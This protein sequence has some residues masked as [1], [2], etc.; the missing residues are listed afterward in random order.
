MPRPVT[1]EARLWKGGRI[2]TGRRWVEALLVEDGRVVAAGPATSVV[3]LA[4]TGTERTDLAG[5]AVVP[6]LIDAHLHPTEIARQREGLD[7]TGVASATE[8]VAA[9]E[10]YGAEARGRPV[11]GRGWDPE[12]WADRR[13]PD[14]R[15][16][17]RAVPD[18]VTIL[19]HASGHAALANA[20]AL[21]AIGIDPSRPIPESPTIGRFPDGR[22]NGLLFEESMTPLGPLVAEAVPVGPEE[23][24]RVA[25]LLASSGIT[26]VGA[27]SMPAGEL[28]ALRS[29]AAAG[30]LPLTVRGYVR[31]GHRRALPRGRRG[32]PSDAV[33]ITGVKLFLDGA[34][35]PRT[36]ALSL[37]YSDDPMTSGVDVG[38]DNDLIAEIAD[39]RAEGLTPALH[40]IGDRAVAR[41]VRLIGSVGRGETA[42]PRIEHAGLV[43]PE[44]LPRLAQLR[45]VL[46]VQPGFVWSDVWLDRRLGSDRARWAYPFR[47]LL[48][49][50]IPLAGSSDAPFDPVDPWRGVRASLSRLGPDG[51]SANPSGAEAL[52]ME[53]ALG[54]YLH[55]AAAALGLDNH[56]SLEA[57]AVADLVVLTAPTLEAAMTSTAA[58]IAETWVGGR[59]VYSADRVAV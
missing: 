57:G 51:R 44:L 14:R 7:L 53:Q 24:A 48:A 33:A 26:A 56:G 6:G 35:G 3:P 49:H 36:A 30:R 42:A 59:R 16:L 21:A 38:S 2:Y 58:P 29:L 43:P 34:F 41:A 17:D 55:G 10:R 20:T 1:G 12:R 22:P 25:G 39:A 31:L 13:W 19:Y 54:L 40:A 15:E 52:T 32:E 47:T 4:G 45:P 37:P 5:L 8:L 27:M 28:D 9:V 18:S 50:G 11:A 46:V 23:L